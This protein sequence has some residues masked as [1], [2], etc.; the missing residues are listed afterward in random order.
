MSDINLEKL[1]VEHQLKFLVNLE[2]LLSGFIHDLNN[3]IAVV[4]GQSSIMKTLTQMNKITDEK[5]LNGSE[6]I[7]NSTK[8]MSVIIQR[9]RDFYKPTTIDQTKANVK[10]ALETTYL[11]SYPKI[12]RADIKV[13]ANLF[14]NELKADVVP[15]ELNLMLWNIHYYFLDL[16]ESIKESA[17]LK[18]STNVED[19]F[20]HITYEL[21]NCEIT[22]FESSSEVTISKF[23]ANKMSG[24]IE[25]TSPNSINIKLP[26]ID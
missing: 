10:L 2:I 24:A 1:I 6:K 16:L 4:A 25:I 18:I 17:S 3:P 14:E 20:A 13:E 12:F 26:L 22:N 5:T 8:K 11:L 21:K 15:I 19:K 9:L 7:L 23:L